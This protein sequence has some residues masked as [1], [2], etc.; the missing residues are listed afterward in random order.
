MRG[1]GESLDWE[2]TQKGL[3][4]RTCVQDGHL[5]LRNVEHGGYNLL[6]AASRMHPPHLSGHPAIPGVIYSLQRLQCKKVSGK[7][8]ESD[9][10]LSSR[11]LLIE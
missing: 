5:A 2:E 4:K 7:D 1:G 11:I 6:K 3:E 10:N 9:F 8:E